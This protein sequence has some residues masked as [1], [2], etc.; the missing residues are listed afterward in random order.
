MQQWTEQ[1]KALDLKPTGAE[2]RPAATVVLVRDGADGL[3]VLLARRAASLD[4]HGGAWVF[5]GGRI[6]AEDFGDDADD[7]EAAARRGAARE[8]LE[9]AGVHVDA[10]ALV[11]L[12]SWTT[13]EISPKRFATWFFVG[14][15][16]GGDEQADGG[17][18][19][20]LRWFRPADALAAREAGE[21]ELAPPQ[22]V[23]LLA[24]A[25]YPDAAAALAGVA[26]SEPL[27]VTPRIHFSDGPAIAIYDDDIAYDDVGRLDEDGP[28][29]RLVMGS[30]GWSYERGP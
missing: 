15:V 19:T 3:E 9:E 30:A 27:V 25:E 14:E 20:E 24:V 18:T 5:P 22:Y 17:E 11:Y 6:D 29:H 26:A 23:S 10:E 1:V 2:V 12:S 13:P 7:L 16:G 21:I 8:A 28:R 4:F